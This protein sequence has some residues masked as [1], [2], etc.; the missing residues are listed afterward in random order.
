MIELMLFLTD[1]LKCC[2]LCTCQPFR[3]KPIIRRYPRKDL[4]LRDETG[5][6]VSFLLHNKCCASLLLL[7]IT[8]SCS[9][10]DFLIQTNLP[11][12]SQTPLGLC[13]RLWFCKSLAKYIHLT[14]I[15]SLFMITRRMFTFATSETSLLLANCKRFM[16]NSENPSPWF[17]VSLIE[18]RL[19]SLTSHLFQE[20]SQQ[21]ADRC[22]A[23]PDWNDQP[24]LRVWL[25]VN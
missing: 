25:C 10:L 11:E 21:P 23:W 12:A 19:R 17:L 9:F 1:S 13:D 18:D 22:G 3:Q 20:F 15:L 14:G 16:W 24:M 4:Q 8:S 5:T 6:Y 7:A 2:A